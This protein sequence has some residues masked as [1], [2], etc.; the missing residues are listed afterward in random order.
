MT[1]P[2]LRITDLTVVYRRG[3]APAVDRVS[4]D[5]PSRS[6]VGV[7]GE[8]GSGKTSVAMVAAGLAPATTG[9]VW[10]GG[11]RITTAMKRSERAAVQMVFQDPH[12]SLDP[13]QTIGAGLRELRKLH[14][15]RTRWTTDEELLERVG[16]APALLRRLPHQLSG[17]QAQR[18]SIGRA[19]FLRPRLLIADEPTSG[20][21]V[22]VQA[23]IL[24]LLEEI[25]REE[26]LGILFISHD[27][28]VVRSICET[29]H[30]MKSGTVVESG[31]TKDV[32]D[33]PRDEYTA[34]L[35]A[36]IPGRERRQRESEGVR[37]S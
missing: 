20:L 7:V 24:A 32:M 10:S 19:L 4:L 23:Q 5:V 36:A 34:T 21:D 12:G 6:I 18:V 27:L 3:A 16:L 37:D 26:D 33:D 29:V 8:S 25:R 17:G 13:R 31:Q 28:A 30:V 15:E 22:S 9:E 11:V 14:P 35:L 1:H 2:A